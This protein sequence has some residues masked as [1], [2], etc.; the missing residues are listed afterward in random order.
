MLKLI[1]IA[2]PLIV[3]AFLV[4]VAMQP[5][6]FRITP[7]AAISAPPGIV[8]AQVNDLHKWER[9]RRGRKSIP[10]RR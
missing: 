5:S 9:G 2:L 7:S 10:P 3:V 1:L 6:D 4:Y 8:F